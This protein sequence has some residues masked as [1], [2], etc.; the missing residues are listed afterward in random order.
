MTKD[1]KRSN[2]SDD[3][4]EKQVILYT[5]AHLEEARIHSDHECSNNSGNKFTEDMQ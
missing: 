5:V 2:L 4:L 1:G 3:F